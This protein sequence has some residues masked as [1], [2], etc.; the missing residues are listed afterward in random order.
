MS[1]SVY[2]I[3]LGPTTCYLIK[4]KGVILFDAGMPRKIN[5]FKKSLA[6]IPVD[7]TEIS[8]IILSHSHFDH[9]GTAKDIREFTGARILVHRADDA[10]LEQ[11]KTV[12]P[13]GVTTWG[14]INEKRTRIELVTGFSRLYFL[15]LMFFIF[16]SIN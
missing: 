9:A 11:S 5:R 10:L 8:L 7:P 15:I 3:K 1:P 4:D 16:G 13:K 14:R 12:W 6:K 2:P